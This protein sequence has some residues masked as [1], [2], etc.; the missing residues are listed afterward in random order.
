[1][2]RRPADVGR[3]GRGASL[4]PAH[5]YTEERREAADDGWGGLDAAADEALARFGRPIGAVECTGKSVADLDAVLAE[6]DALVAEKTG[7]AAE[8]DALVE[9]QGYKSFKYFE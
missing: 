9:R 5:R 2:E 7:L 8:R 1:M 4:N 3:K 6:R